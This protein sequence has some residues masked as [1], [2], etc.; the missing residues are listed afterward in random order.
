MKIPRP[1][2]YQEQAIVVDWWAHV[3]SSYKLPEFALFAVP[4]GAHL[5]GD[6]KK[7]GIQMARLKASGLRVGMV[8]LCLD[9]PLKRGEAYFPGLRIEMKRKPN[10]PS[11]EQEEVILYLRQRGYHVCVC[12][13]AD[14]AMRAIKGYLTA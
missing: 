13:S 2:E 7:R 3:C 12:Y 5:A 6:A 1:T 14:E 10:K 11:P 8:D 9:V 4:N